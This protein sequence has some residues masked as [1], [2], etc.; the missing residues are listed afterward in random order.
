MKIFLNILTL[1]IIASAGT[2]AWS[3]PYG[4]GELSKEQKEVVKAY[5]NAV[6]LQK[7]VRE[8][9]NANAR[10]KKV[11][12]YTDAVQNLEKHC[13]K[14]ECSPKDPHAGSDF[15]LDHCSFNKRGEPIVNSEKGESSLAAAG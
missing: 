13:K 1:V 2:S 14:V 4:E 6:D 9:K 10:I 11:N 12:Q 8:E 5:N 3:G 15:C 7:K